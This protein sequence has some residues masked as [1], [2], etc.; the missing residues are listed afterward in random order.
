MSLN[1]DPWPET[2]R[3]SMERTKI[4]IQQLDQAREDGRMTQT[5]SYVADEENRL[6]KMVEVAQRVEAGRS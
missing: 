4:Y 2:V 1:I 3:A 6:F 5:K